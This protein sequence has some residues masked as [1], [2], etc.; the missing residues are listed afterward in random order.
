[1]SNN[2]NLPESENTVDLLA[3]CINACKGI[4]RGLAAMFKGIGTA[5][6]AC[7]GFV[8]RHV[9]LLLGAGVC[10]LGIIILSG[11]TSLKHYLEGEA[12]VYSSVP[13][14]NIELE[15]DKLNGHAISGHSA[16]LASTIGLDADLAKKINSITFGYGMDI[17]N[18]GQI[19]YAEYVKQRTQD[20]YTEKTLKGGNN[21][22]QIV[23]TPTRIKIVNYG[24]L[25]V[26]TSTSN[27]AEFQKISHAICDYLNQQPAL[28][29]LRQLACQ[30]ME[31]QI[32]EITTQRNI[33]DS[34]LRIEYF[35]NSKL[36]AASFAQG[37][38]KLV[39]ADY[40][41]DNK[42]PYGSTVDYQDIINLTDKKNTLTTRLAKSQEVIT[43]QSDFVPLSS[44][45]AS[46]FKYSMLLLWM[47]CFVIGTLIY[48]FRKPIL[49]YI[50]KQRQK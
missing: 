7:V 10:G 4:G 34:L 50:R 31:M 35:I 14:K 39:L 8:V 16:L 46:V 27:S 2:P 11:Q 47:A 9:F 42:T 19:D 3:L 36:R 13:L 15:I 22:D 43:I 18:D 17:D 33:L 32:A 24:F 12:L 20:L 23:K 49:E 1:M 25:N 5:I 37:G 38:N 30:E 26:K 21:G 29:M 45:S 28:R 48:D 44:S 41:N 6:A 40:K